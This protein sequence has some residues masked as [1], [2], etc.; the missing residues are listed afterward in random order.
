MVSSKAL[1]SKVLGVVNAILI[2]HEDE[3]DDAW[4]LVP[5][6]VSHFTRDSASH[7]H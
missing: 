6:T 3:L 1:K 4:L 5:L 2:K 7:V